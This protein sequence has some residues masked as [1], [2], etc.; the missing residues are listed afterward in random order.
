MNDS[1]ALPW[2][3]QLWPPTLPHCLT[4]SHLDW[5]GLTVSPIQANFWA[6]FSLV[7]PLRFLCAASCSPEQPRSAHRRNHRRSAHV[8][9]VSLSLWQSGFSVSLPSSSPHPVSLSYISHRTSFSNTQH[10]PRISVLCSPNTRL[11][12]MYTHTRTVQNELLCSADVHASVLWGIKKLEENTVAKKLGFISR[13]S[14]LPISSFLCLVGE[15][16]S[17]REGGGQW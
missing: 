12:I 11:A 9:L 3:V 6:T 16:Y 14:Y 4:A 8:S 7:Q 1:G 13:V 10:L 15:D 17:E 5:P 2:D